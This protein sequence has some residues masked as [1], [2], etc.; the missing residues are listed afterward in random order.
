M[1]WKRSRDCTICLRLVLPT[2]HTC[3]LLWSLDFSS[4][5]FWGWM[6]TGCATLSPRMLS[7]FSEL[8]P[9]FD[10]FRFCISVVKRKR[11]SPGRTAVPRHSNLRASAYISRG[12]HNTIPCSTER[13]RNPKHE[14]HIPKSCQQFGGEE[15]AQDR[16]RRAKEVA[17]GMHGVIF[18]P[19]GRSKALVRS[20]HL[21]MDAC[22]HL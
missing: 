9:F 18:A 11:K 13:G 5:S 3:G 20:N 16:M 6:A 21:L 8:Q 12:E 4:G 19:D 2:N 22:I 17:S 14:Y 7:K 1:T 10:Q 15:S